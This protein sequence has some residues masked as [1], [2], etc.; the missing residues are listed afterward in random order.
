M[1]SAS[2]CV[3]TS[4]QYGYYCFTPEHASII[5]GSLEQTYVSNPIYKMQKIIA[6]LY[7]LDHRLKMEYNLGQSAINNF[8]VF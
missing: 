1:H 3:S 5:L 8:T 7:Q 4:L 2:N 6:Q